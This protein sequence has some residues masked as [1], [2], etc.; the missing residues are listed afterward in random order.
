VDIPVVILSAEGL[1][2][3]I[4]SLLKAGARAYLTKPFQ[5]DVILE[6][7]EELLGSPSTD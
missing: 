7:M 1:P 3:D 4:A 6:L 5:M 2:G